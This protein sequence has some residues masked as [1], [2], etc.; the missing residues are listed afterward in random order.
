M[1]FFGVILIIL[2]I[3]GFMS[4]SLKKKYEA[5][6]AKPDDE[7]DDKF[8]NK[9]SNFD[10]FFYLA[11]KR[12]NSLLLF[13]GIVL[14][15]WNGIFFWAD[16]GKQYFLVFP[17]GSKGAVMSQGIKFK[18][19]AK[20]TDWPKWIDIA[21]FTEEEKGKK[22]F[23]DSEIEGVMDPVNVRFI[24]QVTGDMYPSLRFQIPIDKEDFMEFA[25]KYRTVEN[26]VYN[27][28]IPS[29]KEQCINTGYMYTAQDYIS[30]AAQ[31]FR[32]TFDEMLT[33]GSYVVEKQEIRDT[34]WTEGISQTNKDR[35]VKDIQIRYLVKKVIGPDGHPLRVKHEITENKLIVSQAIVSDLILDPEYRERLKEQKAESA[36]RQLEQQKI[37]TA[38]IAQQRVIAEGEQAKA[39]ERVDQ[40]TKQVAELI[41]IETRLKK[42]ET[43]RKLSKI[44]LETEKLETERKKVAAD[45]TYYEN[46][47]RVDAGLT[48]QERA[49]LEKEIRIGVAKEVA[50]IKFPETMIITGDKEGGTPLESLIGAAMAKQLSTDDVKVK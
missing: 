19:F 45:A 33:D 49:Q 29:V 32:Q 23:N 5:E 9:L 1:K 50:K 4:L 35:F 30:G 20:T 46:K 43:N 3:V 22:D 40:E 44:A 2:S 13:A 12:T 47:K 11:K 18:A 17:W 16:A 36:K 28:L 25:I 7:R 37:E 15:L 10:K 14:I 31:S 34:T 6:K 24:D 27:T 26:L 39:Q 42:E 48:P 38:K 41:E 8:I 21:A